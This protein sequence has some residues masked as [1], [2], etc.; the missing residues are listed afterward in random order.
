MWRML[1]DG[2]GKDGRER[3]E[4]RKEPP[5]PPAQP[6]E[7]AMPRPDGSRIQIMGENAILR[8][9]QRSNGT[10][11]KPEFWPVD[12][13]QFELLQAQLS[14]YQQEQEEKRLA[15]AGGG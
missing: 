14:Q 9:T 15:K 10:W 2:Q 6:P 11:R 5:Q 3:N 13:D 4:R 8:W 1:V 7:E 12:K